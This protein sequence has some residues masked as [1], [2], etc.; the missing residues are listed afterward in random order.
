MAYKK[1]VLS[2]LAVIAGIA[3]LFLLVRYGGSALVPNLTGN[4]QVESD[5]LAQ[6]TGALKD[7]RAPYFD[8]PNVR[9]DHVQLSQF[10]DTPL[11]IV[12]WSTWNSVAADQIKILDDYVRNQSVAQQ[13]VKVVA[14][15]SQEERTIVTSF[16]KRGGYEV[17]TLIDA[18][19]DVSEKYDIKSVPTFFFLDRGGVIREEF[20]GVLSEKAIA[21]KTEQ[22]LK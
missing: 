1:Y 18:R 13:F 6:E 17:Q 15:N 19:G 5:S 10:I 14:I 4:I 8:L 2:A 22:L 20:A 3:V 9:G 16:M 12:F 11:V 7:A 21:Q